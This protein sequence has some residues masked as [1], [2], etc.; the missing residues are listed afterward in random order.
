MTAPLLR[1]QHGLTL[2]ELMIAMTL[3]LLVM[4][5]VSNIFIA[6]SATFRTA[7][8]LAGAQENGR[9]AFEMISRE[10]REAGGTPCGAQIIVNALNPVAGG[11]VS[12]SPW[13]AWNAP[14]QGYDNSSSGDGANSLV[15]VGTASTNRLAGTDAIL[16]VNGN[17]SQN[18]TI[19]KHQPSAASLQLSKN[20][21]GLN[22]GDIVM[23]CNYK[24]AT[25]FQITNANAN[26]ATI[27]HNTG[28]SVSPG[29]CT[30][31]LGWR[32]PAKQNCTKP[33]S[34]Q[35]DFTGGSVVSFKPVLWYIGRNDRGGSSLFRYSLN[36]KVTEEMVENVTNMQI[37]YLRK[38]ITTKIP[39]TS[40]VTAAS[41]TDWTSA[42]NTQVIATQITLTVTTKDAISTHTPPQK[43]TSDMYATIQIRT[44]ESL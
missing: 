33:T 12:T 18:L 19:A 23:A 9:M 28:N 43:L 10:I 36:D 11:T 3:G 41:I 4:I 39:D 8:N 38:N 2:V 29:N 25:I 14:I 30:K 31:G 26:N 44:R 37:Q 13:L 7:D 17:S 20:N 24:N 15:P 21:H 32:D 1:Y 40:Y 5:G 42:S 22:S 16:L 27:V 6:N 35:E 34:Y